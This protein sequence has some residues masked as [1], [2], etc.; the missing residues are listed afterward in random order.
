MRCLQNTQV[1]FTLPFSWN[2][3]KLE[4]C[5]IMYAFIGW[6]GL[7]SFSFVKHWMARFCVLSLA[8]KGSLSKNTGTISQ[9]GAS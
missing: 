6:P 5:G 3:C 7:H 8:K 1:Y 2:A 9:P 4:P